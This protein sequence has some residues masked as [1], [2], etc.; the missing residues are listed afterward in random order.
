MHGSHSNLARKLSWFQPTTP[1][2]LLGSRPWQCG[3]REMMTCHPGAKRS[4]P[5]P[6]ILKQR[7]E[8]PAVCA[9]QAL[10]PGGPPTPQPLLL[11]A[12]PSPGA[13]WWFQFRVVCKSSAILKL[14][15]MSRRDCSSGKDKVDS[16]QR[17]INVSS[18]VSCAHS[19]AAFT[20]PGLQPICR[21]PGPACL[22]GL[23]VSYCT[24]T[25]ALKCLTHLFL[26]CLHGPERQGLQEQ[27]GLHQKI[28]WPV[29]LVRPR[30]PRGPRSQCSAGHPV[31]TPLSPDESTQPSGLPSAGLLPHP[32]LS[33]PV[34]HGREEQQRKT[35]AFGVTTPWSS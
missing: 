16:T 23:D 14:L 7:H 12:W 17:Q 5:D 8:D 2:H 22:E 34:T 32:P 27:K 24:H 13:G 20:L 9:P 3:V 28:G 25:P 33:F 31:S 4:S 6:D 21:P 30:E 26:S 15:N 18:P 19:S 1:S 35:R 11:P 10:A 29:G